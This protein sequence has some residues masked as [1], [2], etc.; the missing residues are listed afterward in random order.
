MPVTTLEEL[1]AKKYIE[2]QLPGWDID[3]VF[4]VKLQRV[5]L[6]DLASKGKIPNPLIGTVVEIFKG[7]AVLPEDETSL[8]TINELAELFAEATM[9][10]PTFKEVEKVIGLTDEQKIIIYNYAI[11]GVKAL[12]PFRKKQTDTEPIGNESEISKKTK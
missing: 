2:V 3:D 12:E 7:N 10:E 6:L 4:N 9:V 8:K 11:R 5:N 1:K